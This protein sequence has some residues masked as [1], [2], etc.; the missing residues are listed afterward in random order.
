MMALA[1]KLALKGREE[2]G[3][4]GAPSSKRG[5]AEIGLSR[6]HVQESLE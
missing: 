2:G 1:T 6:E 5:R 4:N 3:G